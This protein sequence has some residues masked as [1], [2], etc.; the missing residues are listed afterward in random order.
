MR[1]T[2]HIAAT[3]LGTTLTDVLQYVLLGHVFVSVIA[4][5][6][7]FRLDYNERRQ[8]IAQS[9]VVWAV[10][11]LGALTVLVFQSVVHKNMTTKASPDIAHHNNEEGLVADVLHDFDA[12]D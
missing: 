12:S 9:I 5:A 2:G 1:S 11:A 8:A 7:I 4:T 3:G 10:P 6:I